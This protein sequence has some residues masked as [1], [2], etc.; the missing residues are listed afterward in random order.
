MPVFIPKPQSEAYI[1]GWL[2]DVPAR[3]V[4][5]TR[6]SRVSIFFLDPGKGISRLPRIETDATA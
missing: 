5:E 2:V 6:E 4:N 1:S 3:D